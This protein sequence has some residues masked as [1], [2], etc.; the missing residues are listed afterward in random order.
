MG[1]KNPRGYFITGTDTGV[2]KTVASVMMLRALKSRG[3]RVCGMKPVASGCIHVDG[4]LVS[5]D[6][7]QLIENSSIRPDYALVNPVALLAPC[8]PNIAAEIEGV[9]IDPE[10]ILLAY[11]ELAGHADT[12]VVEGVGGWLSPVFGM[13]GMELLV[14]RLHLSV[15]L[16]VGVRLGCINHALLTAAAIRS[17]GFNIAGWIANHVDPD[18]IYSEHSV[19]CLRAALECKL[20]GEIP[21]R[22][23][24]HEW[25]DM[26]TSLDIS[27]LDGA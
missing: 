6:A 10:R 26:G 20:I 11:S 21:Y 5:D 22:M 7:M 15:I 25:I 16:V 27:C 1:R 3:R 19:S 9:D 12:I 14:N 8:S 23:A 13:T 4:R 18:F 17:S 24:R 2:G